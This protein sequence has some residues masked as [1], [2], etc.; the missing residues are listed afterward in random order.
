[1][2]PKRD[3]SEFNYG[4]MSSLVVNQGERDSV[5]IQP[6]QPLNIRLLYERK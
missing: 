1:M 3:L 6:L 2:P 5:D 4:A